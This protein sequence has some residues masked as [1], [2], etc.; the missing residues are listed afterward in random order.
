MGFFSCRRRCGI[1]G[2]RGSGI[3]SRG[4]G[5]FCVEGWRV[6]E[7]EYS[8]GVLEWGMDIGIVVRIAAG[9]EVA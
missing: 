3:G 7:G 8:G 6:G 9:M 4:S 1:R 5:G 2:L